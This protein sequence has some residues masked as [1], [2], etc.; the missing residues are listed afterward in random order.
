[1]RRQ[2]SHVHVVSSTYTDAKSDWM[3]SAVFDVTTV[4]VAAQRPGGTR[5]LFRAS[6]SQL[7]V[8]GFLALYMEG[9][10]D[11][12]PRAAGCGCRSGSRRR[13]V[14]G[15]QADQPPTPLAI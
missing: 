12:E 4:D 3:I 15:K 2:H 9:Q 5:Y 7:R 6:G 11:A 14:V 13:R 1:V 8:P 10:D